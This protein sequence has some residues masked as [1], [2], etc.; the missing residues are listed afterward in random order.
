MVLGENERSSRKPNI[1]SKLYV[2]EN[3]S[4]YCFC[5]SEM[6]P[7]AKKT[8]LRYAPA[9]DGH[10]SKNSVGFCA[11]ERK[12]FPTAL[13]LKETFLTLP[14]F[15][16]EDIVGSQPKNSLINF[17]LNSQKSFFSRLRVIKSPSARALA[18]MMP[19]SN[20]LRQQA[21]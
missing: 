18:E 4:I 12:Y 19:E 8:P 5:G 6:L 16:E 11:K 7:H 20:A 1:A 17:A 3:S 15:S 14:P 2:G 21:F 13:L 9:H 10:F